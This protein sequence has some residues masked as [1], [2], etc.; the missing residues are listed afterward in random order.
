MADAPPP[1]EPE[2]ADEGAPAWMA[3]FAD[4]MSL[5][6]TF[7]VLLLSF[8]NM[9]IK[10]FQTALGSVREAMGVQFEHPGDRMGLTTSIVELSKRESTD[11]LHTLDNQ[12]SEMFK[13]LVQGRG[14]AEQISVGLGDRGIVVRIKNTVLFEPGG[15]TL[16]KEAE[17][18]LMVVGDA[19]RELDVP[20]WIEGHTDNRPIRSARFPSNWELSAGRAVSTLRFLQKEAR[21]PKYRMHIAGY[22]D[23]RPLRSNVTAEGRSENRRV[24]FVFIQPLDKE[25]DK[26]R[27]L[28]FRANRMAAKYGLPP[29]GSYRGRAVQMDDPNSRAPATKPEPSSEAPRGVLPPGVAPSGRPPRPAPSAASKGPAF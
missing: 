4:L 10:N 6:L 18:P 29:I 1:P 14:A 26:R 25:E 28:L 21:V 5:L 7:F 3:T 9:D 17:R 12:V 15:T 20:L 27:E 22:A 19:A 16:T 8:A 11:K 13:K 2:E 23:T 24:E